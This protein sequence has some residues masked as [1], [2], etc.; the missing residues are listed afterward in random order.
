VKNE[1]AIPLALDFRVGASYG[2]WLDP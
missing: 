2:W 1:D